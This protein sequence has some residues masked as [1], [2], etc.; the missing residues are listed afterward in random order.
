[1]NL[2]IQYLLFKNISKMYLINI[3]YIYLRH[4]LSI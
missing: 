1:M 4:V 3:I 2:F